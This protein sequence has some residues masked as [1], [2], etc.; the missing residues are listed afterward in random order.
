[1]RHLK[2][3]KK[4]FEEQINSYNSYVE[5]AMATMQRGK[6]YVITLHS[7]AKY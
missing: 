4:Y 6:S 5:V 1:L 3:R 2:E 7:S